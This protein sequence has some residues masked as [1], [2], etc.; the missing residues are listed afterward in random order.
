MHGTGRVFTG[1]PF[2]GQASYTITVWPVEPAALRPLTIAG[3]VA[4]LLAGWLLVAALARRRLATALATAGLAAATLPAYQFCREAYEV[5]V[6]AHGSPDPYIVDGSR[7]GT[8]TLICMVAGLLAIVA[9]VIVAR[10]RPAVPA[11]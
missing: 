1:Y 9:A 4:G 2:A 5:M 8:L 7:G 11:G 3:L 6:Y 10:P